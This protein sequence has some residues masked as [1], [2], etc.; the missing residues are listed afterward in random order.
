MKNL[1]N[2]KPEYEIDLREL[3]IAL[4]AY[5]LLIIFTCALSIFYA[6]YLTLNTEKKFTSTTIF[7]LGQVNPGG[8]N[9]SGELNALAN[10][11]G[12][13]IKNNDTLP[14]DL[15]TGRIFIEKLDARLN[16]QGDPYFNT[17]NPNSIDPAWKSTIKRA[18]GWQESSADTQEAIWQA[19]V[20]NYSSNVEFDETENKASMIVVTHVDSQ[21][22]AEIAN[23]I[24]D[25]IT[26]EAKKKNDTE[27]D[28]QLNYLS[29]TLANALNDLETAQ[30]NLKEFSLENSALPLENFAISSLRLDTLREQLGRTSELHEAVIA[31]SLMLENKTTD[32][33]NYLILRQKF[34]IIDQVEFRRVLGQN[35]ITSS[36]SWPKASSVNAVLATLSER[37][38][39]LE[40]QI[41]TSQLEATQLGLTV[42]TYSKL[43][44]NAEVAEATYTVLIEQ[45]KAQSII[46]GYRPDKTEVYDY[47]TASITPSSPNLKLNLIIG[48]VLGLFLGA[49]LSLILTQYRDVYNSKTSL[50][51]GSQ[52][53]YTASVRDLLPLRNKSLDKLNS[54][55]M[56]KPRSILRELAVEV[57]KNNATQVVVTSS[58]AKI[59]SNDLARVLSSYMQSN[60]MKIAVIDFSP[61]AKKLDI[62][63]KRLS[64]GSFVVAESVEHLVVLRPGGD[65]NA[66]D[67]LSQKGFWENIQSVNSEFDLVFL[68]ADNNNAI[69]L[70]SALEGKKMFHITIARTKKTKSATLTKMLS[71]LPIQ[72]LLYD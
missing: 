31:L 32:Q 12:V 63:D 46:A 47:A 26:S 4:W 16:F 68:C 60:N 25:E 18:I 66:M 49:T 33:K 67:M 51:A 19:I 14:I 6:G 41:N 65:L 9:F 38:T 22:A 37:I 10:F 52:A 15:F 17:Y 29:N 72:G 30:F 48:A 50:R 55:L 2:S 11:A 1:L 20:R 23:V 7:K 27:Q 70:L 35:E 8:I 42:E 34:P 45:V 5:K 36:W 40:V 21:R 44:R 28:K 59:T 3:F 71:L 24:M 54:I 61:M 64:I 69:S 43:Q 57:Y 58:R 13:G 53:R 56:K 62:D 39:R